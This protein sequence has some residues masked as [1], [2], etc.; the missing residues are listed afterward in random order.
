M[1]RYAVRVRVVGRRELLPHEVREAIERIEHTTQHN[2]RRILNICMPYSA[3]DEICQ[4]VTA[5]AQRKQPL[6]TPAD[7]DNELMVP[8]SVP[9]DILVRTS[10]VS[11]LSDFLLWQVRRNFL[12]G[13]DAQ[14]NERTQLHFIDRF[15]P[16]FG[17][18]DLVP[19]ILAY[20]RDRLAEESRALAR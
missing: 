2:S 18:W 16:Q 13:A 15:W 7:L 19:I 6:I 8:G 17:L 12:G 4:A 9:V 1:S 14:C 20:Q 10:N 5:H 11:R 3:Q